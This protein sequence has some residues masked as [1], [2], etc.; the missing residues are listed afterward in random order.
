[1]QFNILF[2]CALKALEI[3]F[4]PKTLWRGRIAGDRSEGTVCLIRISLGLEENKQF[5]V[6]LRFAALSGDFFSPRH[7]LAQRRR[8]GKKEA[9]GCH[10]ISTFQ[11]HA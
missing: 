8:G 2:L 10:K 9:R 3:H 4:R 5:S 11:R 6:A 1:M 7:S